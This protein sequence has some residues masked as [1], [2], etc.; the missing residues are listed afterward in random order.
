MV[1]EMDK[2]RGDER[3]NRIVNGRNSLRDS[4]R[5]RETDG[6]LRWVEMKKKDIER[7]E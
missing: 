3:K 7:D 1:I 5:E 4:E 2:E 6:G